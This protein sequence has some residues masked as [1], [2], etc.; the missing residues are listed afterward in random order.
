MRH[1]LIDAVRPR[2]R[3]RNDG[4]GINC[5]GAHSLFRSTRGTRPAGRPASLGVA[6]ELRAL[7]HEIISNQSVVRRSFSRHPTEGTSRTNL[8]HAPHFA[9]D[10]GRR[11]HQSWPHGQRSVY[12]CG[13][14]WSPVRSV[15]G[16]PGRWMDRCGDK[17]PNRSLL[18]CWRLDDNDNVFRPRGGAYLSCTWPHVESL[19]PQ[20]VTGHWTRTID[21][22]NAVS[23]MHVYGRPVAIASRSHSLIVV[24]RTSRMHTAGVRTRTERVVNLFTGAMTWDWVVRPRAAIVARVM[25][26]KEY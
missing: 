1:P 3:K 7:Q 16:R 14:W 11:L 23:A 15:D 19:A 12:C 21:R 2:Q 24:R 10:Y 8:T 5:T 22:H 25:K 20:R 18:L 9:I 26:R 4:S 13:H 17:S 6:V